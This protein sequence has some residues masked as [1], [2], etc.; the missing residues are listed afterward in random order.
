MT[1]SS[2]HSPRPWLAT[3]LALLFGP[4]GALYTSGVFA[5]LVLLV[6]LALL[7]LVGLPPQGRGA[8]AALA[9]GAGAFVWSRLSLG[10]KLPPALRRFDR[11]SMPQALVLGVVIFGTLLLMT[12]TAV[13]VINYRG[14]SMAPALI[15][16]DQ[17]SAVLAPALRGEVHRGDLIS[18][19]YPGAKA[20]IVSRV[21]GV[22]GDTVEVRHGVLLVGG[23]VADD[24][25]A[26]AALQA[27]GCV[28]EE[29]FF[30]NRAV[31]QKLGTVD[32]EEDPAPVPV[33]VGSVAVISDNRSDLF[34]DSR[35]FGFLPLSEIRAKVTVS[36][37][38]Y[39]GMRPED[40]L[41]PTNPRR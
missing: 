10:A 19:R 15:S 9:A 23:Q 27:A 11:L 35:A 1:S 14:Y 28:D 40:C 31:A 26:F 30:N 12:R 21:V 41:L 2:T 5:F 8:A 20:T 34:P 37:P 36:Q 33:P 7:C 3:V 17:A 38:D 16:G 29:L 32:E 6:Y 4:W 24:P 25:A 18:F 39:A 22:A 13:T